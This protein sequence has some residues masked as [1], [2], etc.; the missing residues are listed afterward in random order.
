MNTLLPRLLLVPALC[1]LVACAPREVLMPRLGLESPALHDFPEDFTPPFSQETGRRMPGFGGGGAAQRTPVIFVHGNTVSARYWLPNRAYFARAGYRPS[2]LWALGYGWDNV[3]YFDSND[4]S[5]PSLQRT[6]DRVTQYVSQQS[7]RPI[8][9][10]DLI[11]HSLGVTVVRQWLKQ[12]NSWHRVRSFIAAC[13]AADGTWTAGQGARGQNRTVAHELAPASPWLQQLNR[14]G[15]T[16][17]PTRYLTL[18]DGNGWSDVLFPAPYEH[19]PALEGATNLAWNLEHGTHYDHLELPRQPDTMDAMLAFLR[20]APEPLPQ[21]AP[22]RIRREGNRLHAEPETAALHCMAGGD[23]PSARTPGVTQLELPDRELLS[24]YARDTRSRLASPIARYRR[25]DGYRAQGTLK[26]RAEPPAGVYEEPQS[27]R[28][29]ASDPEAFIV[30]STAGL[31]PDSGG[32]LYQAPVHF[33]APL[34]LIAVA[35]TPDGRV[36]APLTLDYDISLE[37][38]EARHSLQRQFQPDTPVRYRQQRTKGR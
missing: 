38:L 36:S 20:A 2:E 21:A 35:M 18:Y 11:A 24:C 17:G 27:V 6:V 37:Y 26:L 33:A 7:G 15:E 5:V 10:V 34:R 9:Q 23:Y 3:R 29:L 16:P 22:P 12:T 25:H 31:V 1:A 30:Y 32:A 14:G 13:G 19:S 8:R 28:L 4:L